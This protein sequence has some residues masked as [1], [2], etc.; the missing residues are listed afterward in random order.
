M[1]CDPHDQF[2]N[3]RLQAPSYTIPL[4][5]HVGPWPAHWQKTEAALR[6]EPSAPPQRARKVQLPWCDGLYRC[7]YCCPEGQ[8]RPIGSKQC[9]DPAAHMPM[10]LR[11]Q[12]VHFLS[13]NPQENVL[14]FGDPELLEVCAKVT[15][16]WGGQGCSPIYQ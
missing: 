16:N 12:Y 10:G 14:R 8:T 4:Q 9:K 3:G 5:A 2:L 6:L 1:C 13:P 7:V 11:G 15:A